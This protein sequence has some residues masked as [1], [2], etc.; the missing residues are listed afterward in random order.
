MRSCVALAALLLVGAAAPPARGDGGARSFAPEFQKGFTLGGWSRDDYAGP[1]VG[2]QLEELQRA[3]VEWLALTP[4][5]LQAERDSVALAPDPAQSPSDASLRRVVATARSLGLRVFLKPQVDLRGPGWRGEIAFRSEAAWSAWF[6]SYAE[7]ISHYARLAEEEHA[8]LFCVGVE[9]DAARHR[10]EDWRAVIAAVRALYSGPLVYA[11]NWKRERDIS[12]WDAL[13]YAG[14]DAYFP[15]APSAGASV[16]EIVAAWRPL[17]AE[18]RAWSERI[19]KPVVL[20][21]IGYRSLR[22]AGRAPWEWQRS[23]EASPGEQER[24]YRAAFQA[25]WSEPWLFGFYWWQWR[26]APPSLP[27]ADTGY[28]PQGKPALR[29]IEEFYAREPRC[30]TKRCSRRAAPSL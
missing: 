8:D 30:P 25:L 18:L 21:E 9:L 7:F 14:V 27:S 22:G 17:A 10:D 24:L 13:D 6:R 23:G 19:R 26:T 4:R 12:W 2:R 28:T 29:V 5:W 16:A 3:G 1:E 11:A 15:V 20:T